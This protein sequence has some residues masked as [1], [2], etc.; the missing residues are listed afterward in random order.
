MIKKNYILK[1]I[2]FLKIKILLILFYFQVNNFYRYLW[3]HYWNLRFKTI[4]DNKN[5]NSLLKLMIIFRVGI[6]KIK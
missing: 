3:R 5:F 6:N 4:N 1:I 2:I